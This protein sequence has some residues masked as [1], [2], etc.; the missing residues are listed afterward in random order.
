MITL[1]AYIE[2]DAK[3]LREEIPGLV[4]NAV[5]NGLRDLLRPPVY[6]TLSCSLDPTARSSQGQGFGPTYGVLDDYTP[7]ANTSASASALGLRH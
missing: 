4:I 1:S 3:G 2:R 5:R 7:Q 6:L